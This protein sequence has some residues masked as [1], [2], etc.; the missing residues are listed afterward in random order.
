M[1]VKSLNNNKILVTVFEE[2][3][4]DEECYQD[5]LEDKAWFSLHITATVFKRIGKKIEN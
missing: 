5:L 1:L 3:L 2:H 4:R